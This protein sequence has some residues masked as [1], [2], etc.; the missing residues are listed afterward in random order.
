MIDKP[1]Q[2]VKWEKQCAKQGYEAAAP[3]FFSHGNPPIA[4]IK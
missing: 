4:L 3:A 2:D 1:L